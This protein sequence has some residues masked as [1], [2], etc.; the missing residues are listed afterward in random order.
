M[1]GLSTGGPRKSGNRATLSD[2]ASYPPPSFLTGEKE[3]RDLDKDRE[4][5]REN[6]RERETERRREG[7]RKR[8]HAEYDNHV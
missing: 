3:Q 7:Q 6:D 8:K 2:S 5:G 4:R 1:T